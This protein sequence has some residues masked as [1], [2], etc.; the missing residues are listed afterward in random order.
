[1]KLNQQVINWLRISRVTQLFVTVQR[2]LAV[3]IFLFRF[4]A[5]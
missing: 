4:D 3:K 5:Y 2:E 1:M